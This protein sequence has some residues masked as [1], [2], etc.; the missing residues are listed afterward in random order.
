MNTRGKA[1]RGPHVCL[2]RPQPSSGGAYVQDE[3]YAVGVRY[4][5]SGP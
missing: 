4:L 1:S 3:R 5:T 2:E